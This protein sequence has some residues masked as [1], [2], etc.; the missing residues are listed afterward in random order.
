MAPEV[1]N[2]K[3]Y[4]P[5][6]E[7]F[8]FATVTYE[9]AST[10]RPFVGLSPEV[11]RSAIGSGFLPTIPSK[12][13]AELQSLLSDCWSLDAQQRPEFHEVVPRLEALC[14]EHPLGIESAQRATR[15]WSPFRR[16]ATK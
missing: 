11:F 14:A 6:A 13:P 16:R 3:P 4:C 7:V 10:K 1:A 2:S 9:I 15:A 8:S 12:W 5:R